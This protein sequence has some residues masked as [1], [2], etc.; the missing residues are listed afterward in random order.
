MSTKIGHVLTGS[1]R[2]HIR[3]AAVALRRLAVS[4]NAKEIV[5]RVHADG[6]V[7]L[8]GAGASEKARIAAWSLIDTPPH[9]DVLSE[10]EVPS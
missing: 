7:I 4:C 1:E 9:I 2:A 6:G 10:A 3:S 8:R 5:L